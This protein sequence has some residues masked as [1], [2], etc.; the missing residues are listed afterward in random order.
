MRK[1]ALKDERTR[2]KVATPMARL[3]PGQI[4]PD[5]VVFG[6]VPQTY[7]E[8]SEPAELGVAPVFF[9]KE[10]EAAAPVTG[11]ET[12]AEAAEPEEEPAPA[13]VGAEPTLEPAGPDV[14]PAPG[15][16]PERT[17]KP[18]PPADPLGAGGGDMLDLFREAKTESGDGNLAS[19][20]EDISITELLGDLNGI[21]TRLGIPKRQPKVHQVLIEAPPDAEDVEAEPE[22]KVA[23]IVPRMEKEP[24]PPAP[25]PAPAVQAAPEEDIDFGSLLA[26]EPE[27]GAKPQRPAARAE[28]A[29]PPTPRPKRGLDGNMMMHLIFLGLAISAAGAFGLTRIRQP[30]QAVGAESVQAGD[31]VPGIVLAVVLTPRPTL[32]VST[33]APTASPTPVPTPEAT[34]S[35]TPRA[36]DP[37]IPPAY[38]TYE[39]EYGDT[40]TSIAAA[41]G[42]CPDHVLWNNNRDE[43]TPLYA[44]DE[45]L[46]PDAPGLIYTVH[47][48]DTLA[49]IVRRLN[50]SVEAIT[51]V[52]GNQ[53]TDSTDLVPGD[54]ILVPG[55]VPQGA[56]DLGSKAE[57][58]MSKP[59]SDG[60]IWPFY[61][62]ITTYYGEQRVGYV[63]NAIDIGGL[64]HYGVSVEAIAD[65]TVAFVG[66]DSEYGNNVIVVHADG[67]RSRYAH[68]SK[69]YVSQGDSVSRGQALGALGCSGDSTGTHLHFE[70][71]KDDRP[72]DPLP[73]LTPA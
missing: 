39:V 29:P 72:V 25:A 4:P 18:D 6:R 13:E 16:A 56:L 68:F 35:P 73:Y 37:S 8:E 31:N 61:G 3:Q 63:H 5:A 58:K 28:S 26:R 52:A 57:Q 34:P 47:R 27:P 41:F 54:K 1:R 49:S 40:I 11:Q 38:T 10:P 53:V 43:K 19:E 70:L 23:K 21:T 33:K 42:V 50:S 30:G 15:A 51:G 17:D 12:F 69:V 46:I 48:G 59:S 14:D 20:V 66:N 9:R 62:P 64:G 65:G 67:T 2:R 22:V 36:K 60:Y 7:E 24:T 71:W 32:A 55:G 44:G 45:L